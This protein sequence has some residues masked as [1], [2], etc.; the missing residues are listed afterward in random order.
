MPYWS[1]QR[2][3][4]VRVRLSDGTQRIVGPWG[5]ALLPAQDARGHALRVAGAELLPQITRLHPD[6]D[7][8]SHVSTPRAA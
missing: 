1:N 6:A 3:Y 8:N 2:R 5:L 4:P 7:E